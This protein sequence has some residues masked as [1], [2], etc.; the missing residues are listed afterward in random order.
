MPENMAQSGQPQVWSKMKNPRSVPRRFR[1]PREDNVSRF[2][3][4]PIGK[5]L[6]HLLQAILHIAE[7][8]LI[9]VGGAEEESALRGEKFLCLVM[10]SQHLLAPADEFLHIGFL[11]EREILIN[12][13]L[14]E[15]SED[16]IDLAEVGIVLLV[17]QLNL[18]VQLLFQLRPRQNSFGVGVDFEVVVHRN[19]LAEL[20][21]E[22]EVPLIVVVHPVVVGARVVPS[23]LQADSFLVDE[24]TELVLC[25]LIDILGESANVVGVGGVSMK[26]PCSLMEVDV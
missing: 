9:V 22:L 25:I 19:L 8:P 5:E 20:L 3:V 24:L 4:L 15:E 12:N 17:C 7:V 14:G 1:L 18:I 13:L 16:E 26:L 11:H 10:V 2:S 21:H 6:F 23:L